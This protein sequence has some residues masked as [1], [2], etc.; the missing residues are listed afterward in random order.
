MFKAL[1]CGALSAGAMAAPAMAAPAAAAPVLSWIIT[2]DQDSCHTDIELLGRSN[3]PATVSLVSNGQQVLLKFTKDDMPNRAFLPIEIDRKPYSNLLTRM[4]D[5]KVATMTLS[6]DTLAALRKGGALLIAWLEDEPV[7]ASLAGS[8]QGL[9]DLT[10]CGAQV[11]AQYQAQQQAKAQAE[12]RAEAEARARQLAQAQLAVVEA[13]KKAADAEA[14]KASEEA[15]RQ[16]AEADA[17]QAQQQQQQ[18]Q[19]ADADAARQRQAQEEEQQREYQ[20]G[21]YS[22]RPSYPPPGYYD[23]YPND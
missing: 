23:P 8:Q 17:L 9:T 13:Q 6:D 5:P 18:Q 15:R 10:T 20:R 22:R 2:P 4:E 11:A 21:Y 7:T 14:R 12:Q 3:N 16:K 1:V 19:Q